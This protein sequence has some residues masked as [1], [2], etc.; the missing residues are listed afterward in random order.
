MTLSFQ[1]CFAL[2]SFIKQFAMV[3]SPSDRE[4][5][6]HDAL[7]RDRDWRNIRSMTW[8]PRAYMKSIGYN[9]GHTFCSH[10]LAIVTLVLVPFHG[11]LGVIDLLL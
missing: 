10:T 2:W 7:Q 5:F 9:P 6:K 3:I 11:I 1:E 4:Q 8:H